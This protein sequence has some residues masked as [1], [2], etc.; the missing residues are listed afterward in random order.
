[1]HMND[2]TFPLSC[3]LWSSS[4]EDV[5]AVADLHFEGP[6]LTLR[7]SVEEKE[8][9]RMVRE[10]DGP[11]WTD[12]CVEL[13][14]SADGRNYANFEFSASGYMHAAFGPDRHSRTKLGQA[15]LDTVER[16]VNILENNNHRSR[17]TLEAVID[18]EKAGIITSLPADLYLNLYKCGDG[19]MKPHFLS[20]FPI[21]LPSPDFHRPE[22]FE[23][24]HIG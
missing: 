4:P 20:A 17:W 2:F 3:Y 16:K 18:L 22:F 9:R 19:L 8:L 1:M 11:V 7:F 5:K 14:I 21:D 15:F 6:L 10:D 24:I 13:F 12:S 23:K